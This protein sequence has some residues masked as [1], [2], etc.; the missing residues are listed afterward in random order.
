M[1]AVNSL[2]AG[3]G[4]NGETVF[5]RLAGGSRKRVAEFILATG[6]EDE[7]WEIWEHIAADNP[8]AVVSKLPGG[9][10]D[11][12]LAGAV[13]NGDGE[14][15][16]TVSRSV[17]ILCKFCAN[18]LRILSFLNKSGA[19]EWNRTTDLGLMSPTL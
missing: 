7:L 10:V 12:R 5:R 16:A 15:H 6:V 13:P 19:S 9:T 2:D 8:D 1:Q 14:F 18:I 4:V 3:R 17:R 11:F